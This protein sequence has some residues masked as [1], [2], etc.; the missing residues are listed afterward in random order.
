M[1]LELA[2]FFYFSFFW[3]ST[4]AS[5]DEAASEYCLFVFQHIQ[6]WLNILNRNPVVL[7]LLISFRPQSESAYPK[8]YFQNSYS[9]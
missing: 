2:S 3:E 5:V 8:L 9:F 4:T 6:L 1:W 7:F